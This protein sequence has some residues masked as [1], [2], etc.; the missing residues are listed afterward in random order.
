MF[1]PKT[2][3]PELGKYSLVR[4]TPRKDAVKIGE[5]MIAVTVAKDFEKKKKQWP[6]NRFFRVNTDGDATE[7]R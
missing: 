6:N 5:Y 1:D 7:L 4:V 2:F 3:I